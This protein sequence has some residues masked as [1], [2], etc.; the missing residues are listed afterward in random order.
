[1]THAGQSAAQ[2]RRDGHS[3]LPSWTTSAAPSLA[4]RSRAPRSPSSCT[5]HRLAS[6]L[7][8]RVRASDCRPRRAA[9]RAGSAATGCGVAEAPARLLACE[10]QDDPP[11]RRG[12]SR[13]AVRLRSLPGPQACAR[14]S[15]RPSESRASR[16]ASSRRIEGEI[17][18]SRYGDDRR[19][20]N[21]GHAG[22]VIALLRPRRTS[23]SVRRG[24]LRP[25]S[26]GGSHC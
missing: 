14:A 3:A 8:C 4:A 6:V 16:G 26:R 18:A 23:S 5:W 22:S 7:Q 21:A 2:P 10:R 11:G 9:A 1:V 13:Q 17:A 20:R 19:G 15:R 25:A 12:T 24:C